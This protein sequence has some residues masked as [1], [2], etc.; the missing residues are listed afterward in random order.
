M[1]VFIT[2]LQ[3]Y[4]EGHL[5][6]KW[7]TLPMSKLKLQRIIHDVL[8]EGEAI[9]GTR[10]HEEIFIS[11]SE[12]DITP[13]AHDPLFELNKYVMAIQDLSEHD[14]L[15]LNFLQQ[16]G[17]N[18]YEVLENGI[19]SYEVEIYDYRGTQSLSDTYELLAEDLTEDGVF[20]FIPPPLQSYIDT[21]AIARDLQ[22]EYTEFEPRVLGRIL[23]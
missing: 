13:N 6:G 22:F 5:V 16:E 4:N 23:S 2:D 10:G 3:A 19:D 14:L 1:R 17:F 12:G 21:T 15:K 18:K 11:D 7:T 20:G 9:S 8:A